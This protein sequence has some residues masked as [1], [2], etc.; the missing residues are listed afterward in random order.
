MGPKAKIEI[1]E[2]LHVGLKIENMRC[3]GQN[4]IASTIHNKFL[5][6][7]PGLPGYG[8]NWGDWCDVVNNVWRGSRQQIRKLSV[9][10]LLLFV[11]FFL[12][13]GEC[14]RKRV[15][16]VE[17]GASFYP[18]LHTSDKTTKERKNKPT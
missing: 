12:V 9:K 5:V 18:S 4:Y 7:P 8:S 16:M 11:V 14:C 3:G 15:S 13:A 6:R 1:E 10:S 2:A 17:Y